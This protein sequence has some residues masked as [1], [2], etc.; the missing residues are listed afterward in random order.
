M[1]QLVEDLTTE[2]G[3]WIMEDG[4]LKHYRSLPREEVMASYSSLKTRLLTNS[5]IVGVALTAYC[6]VTTPTPGA[7]LGV[8]LGSLGSLYYLV[9]LSSDIEKL[10]PG[11]STNVPVVAA[12]EIEDVLPRLAALIPALYAQALGSRRVWIP[13]AITLLA[14][15]WN[16]V[17]QDNL[18]HAGFAPALIGFGLGYKMP[19]LLVGWDDLKES[20]MDE[21]RG[22]ILTSRQRPTLVEPEDSGFDIY[23]NPIDKRR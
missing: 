18:P 16:Y 10:Q 19:M 21:E 20:M 15:A 13:V 7:P 22:K 6:T 5:A 4:E 9:D 3:D 8:L 1:A 12:K 23:G 11:P 2:N 17:V 14:T